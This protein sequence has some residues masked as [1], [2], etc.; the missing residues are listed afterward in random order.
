MDTS[1]KYIINLDEWN[2]TQQK[3]QDLL[4]NRFASGDPSVWCKK[5][6]GT[7]QLFS[8]RQAE[9]AVLMWMVFTSALSWRLGVLFAENV[10]AILETKPLR[11]RRIRWFSNWTSPALTCCPCFDEKHDSRSIFFDSR[12]LKSILT[13]MTRMTLVLQIHL[14]LL[15]LHTAIWACFN[16]INWLHPIDFS[17]PPSLQNSNTMAS[18]SNRW[19]QTIFRVWKSEKQ[20]YKIVIYN[21]I[22]TIYIYIYVLF[23]NLQL[24]PDSYGCPILP[25][26]LVMPRHEALCNSSSLLVYTGSHSLDYLLVIRHS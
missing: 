20:L 6:K 9:I 26:I 12:G 5:V 21:N 24:R 22:N 13:H 18:W 25:I 2:K 16:G 3:H 10:E 19:N 14:C 11:I 23:I 1:S 7:S 8:L 17:Q 15:G 4:G